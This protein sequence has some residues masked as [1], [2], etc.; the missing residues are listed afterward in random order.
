MEPIAVITAC[1]RPEL[2]GDVYQALLRQSVDWIWNVQLDGPAAAW[3]APASVPWKGDGRV[4][5]EA[6]GKPMGSAVS[7]NRALMRR[8]ASRVMCV[9]DDDLITATALG[10]LAATLDQDPE[11][12]GVWGATRSFVDDPAVTENFK[13]WH[14]E[15]RIAAGTVLAEFESTG[16]FP[17]HVGAML[18]RREHLLAVGGYAALP[19]SIDTNPFLACEALF[20]HRYVDET[21]YLYRQHAH[22]MTREPEYEASK[23]SV[24]RLNFERAHALER[25]LRPRDP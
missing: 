21:V 10:T 23:M 18:W 14:H 19:R 11:C 12:F 1:T 3:V 17:V 2:L 7:R 20:P 9:D 15:G 8:P 4:S 5:M 22:Q 6:N 16:H 13:G 24:H 25:L